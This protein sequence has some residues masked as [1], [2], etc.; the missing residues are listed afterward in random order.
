MDEI[1]EPVDVARPDDACWR[2]ELALRPGFVAP[3]VKLTRPEYWPKRGYSTA[4]AN[5]SASESGVAA[6]PTTVVRSLPP[7]PRTMLAPVNGCA[8]LRPLLRKVD[9]TQPPEKSP[10]SKPP[11][12]NSA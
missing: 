6:G 3:S 4:G 1:V 8:P 10:A 2:S 5:G 9:F 11:F 7:A 12:V